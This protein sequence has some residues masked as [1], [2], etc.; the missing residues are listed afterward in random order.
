[1]TNKKRNEEVYRLISNV[2]GNICADVNTYHDYLAIENLSSYEHQQLEGS[3]FLEEITE[4]YG[5]QIKYEEYDYKNSTWNIWLERVD[6]EEERAEDERA[7]ARY[8]AM[9]EAKRGFD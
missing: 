2:S 4:L 6:D 1:M 9:K 3:S 7:E 8:E 5:S